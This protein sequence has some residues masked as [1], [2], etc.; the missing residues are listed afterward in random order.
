MGKKLGVNI[1]FMHGRGGTVGRGAV[2]HM[3]L[4][5]LNL[6]AQSMTELE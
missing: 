2:L 5:L 1:T 6:S 3:K 4:L